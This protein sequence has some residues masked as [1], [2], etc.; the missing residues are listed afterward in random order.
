MIDVGVIGVAPDLGQVGEILLRCPDV[1]VSAVGRLA[2]DTSLPEALKSAGNVYDDFR[3]LVAEQALAALFLAGP[4]PGALDALRLAAD[5]AVPVWKIAPPFVTPTLSEKVQ[6]SMTR[7]EGSPYIWRRP[8]PDRRQTR[9]GC[10]P[11]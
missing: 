6:S 3:Q 11:S 1:R 4:L 10:N 9:P 7:A 2:R 5:K 8:P